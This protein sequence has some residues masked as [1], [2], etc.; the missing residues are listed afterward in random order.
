M[1]TRHNFGFLL[2]DELSNFL[3]KQAGYQ[4]TS[5]K[6]MTGIGHWQ[7]WSHPQH[8]PFTLLWPL[9]FMNLSGRAIEH[10]ISGQRSDSFDSTTDLMVVIDDLSL[11]LGTLRLRAKGSS[12]GH[13]GLKSIEAMLGHRDYPRLRLGIG[14][15][16]EG[17]D[18]VD[19]V[20]DPFADD[21][22]TLVKQVSRQGSEF[23]VD[24][25]EGVSFDAV[26]GKVNGWKPNL[27]PTA[28][29]S[30]S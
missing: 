14:S 1:D 29:E 5:E 27:T 20:L 30:E 4:K 19:Y 26:V 2:L 6:K 8:D 15:P 11:S 3:E 21:E 16:K 22:K 28:P 18:I 17:E 10:L 24:W 25:L 13:N 12:G 23:L 7:V 9:T